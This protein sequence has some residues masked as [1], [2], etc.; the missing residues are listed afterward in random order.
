MSFLVSQFQ[1]SSSK[2]AATTRARE[3]RLSF[4]TMFPSRS[5]W[6]VLTQ[7]IS[8][9]Y[10]CYIEIAVDVFKAKSPSLINSLKDFLTCLPSPK[11]IELVL[12]ITIYHL[13]E[14]DPL[15]CRWI[16]QHPDY[17]MPE[18]DLVALA[19]QTIFSKLES[20]GYICEEDFRFE[21]PDR[22]YLSEEVRSSLC[23]SLNRPHCA[24]ERLLLEEVL[25]IRCN[26]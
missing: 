3:S 4:T 5:N 22:F 10:Q 1:D 19:I 11:A 15:V 9:E 20:Q 2:S 21:W 16:L 13:A 23:S 26:L 7:K 12:A 14:T 6:H 24:G 17:L 18:L 25:R 8:S